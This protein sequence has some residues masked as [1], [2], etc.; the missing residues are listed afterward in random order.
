MNVVSL[1]CCLSLLLVAA[2]A[3]QPKPC[4]GTAEYL[5]HQARRAKLAKST[6]PNPIGEAQV[7]ADGAIMSTGRIK[8][9]AFGQRVLVRNLVTAGNHT[10]SVEHLMLFKQNVYYEMDWSRFSCQKKKLDPSFIPMQVPADANHMGQVVI[11]S[12]SSW[13]MGVTVNT[14]YGALPPNGMYMH[15][16]TDAGCF[17]ATLLAF[18]PESGWTAVSTYNWVLGTTD[19][20]D[21]LPPFFCGKSQLEETEKADTFFTA[22]E[23]LAKQSTS[24]Q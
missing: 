20:M 1:L 9:D 10:F 21:F 23:S 24:K 12:L 15:V 16:F 19:P 14:W 3:Q 8:Y 11:G 22:L 5:C 4:G 17:P 18:T 6:W 7:G 13:G 2:A